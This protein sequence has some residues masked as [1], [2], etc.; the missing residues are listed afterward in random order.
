M[1]WPFD[2]AL[3]VT[4]QLV[5]GIQTFPLASSVR[6]SKGRRPCLAALGRLAPAAVLGQESR[7][8]AKVCWR[9]ED[10]AQVVSAPLPV[11]TVGQGPEDQPGVRA[12][13]IS[14][15]AA[16]RS[17]LARRP[18]RRRRVSVLLT[19]TFLMAACTTAGPHS[20]TSAATERTPPST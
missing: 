18:S 6:T 19:L 2:V 12:Q 1:D 11:P 9:W 7:R 20:G 15:D 4:V 13:R 17:A 8:V 14:M 10:L 3:R 16:R 5:A